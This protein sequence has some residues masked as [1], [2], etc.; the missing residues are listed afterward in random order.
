MAKTIDNLGIET[1]TRYAE[2]KAHFD[3]SL[4]KQARI[5]LQ[6]QIDVTHPSFTSEVD[7]LFESDK[8]HTRWADFNPPLGYSKQKRNLFGEFT[9]PR[10]GSLDKRELLLQ[11]LKQM[12]I[13]GNEKKS[14]DSP[15]E[16]IMREKQVFISLLTKIEALD[17]LV[18]DTNLKRDQYHKG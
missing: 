13:G 15:I 6:A 4:I 2:D 10:L 1:S 7:L 14:G 11:K 5:P 3:E 18:I 9:I 17:Q 8:R 12:E 16:H